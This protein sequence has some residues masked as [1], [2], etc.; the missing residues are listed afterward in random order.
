[1]PV[2]GVLNALRTSAEFPVDG[3]SAAIA[4]A[5]AGCPLTDDAKT[6]AKAG[7]LP[8]ARHADKED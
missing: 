5:Y 3:A 4:A 2:V 8:P 1:M 7:A 6:G